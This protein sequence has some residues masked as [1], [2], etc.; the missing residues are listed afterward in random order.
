MSNK[1]WTLEQAENQVGRTAIVTGA[2]VGLGYETALALAG[3]GATVIL[4]C[5]NQEKAAAAR[6][7]ILAVYPNALVECATL[8]TSSLDCVR[9]CATDLL[10]RHDRCDLLI[11]NA[12]IMMTPYQTSVDG[13]ENQLATN[14]IGHFLLTALLLPLITSTAGARVVNLSSLAH[15]WSGIQFHDINFE[16][17]YSRKLAYGQS[18]TACLMFA[19]E[20]Q[21]RLE[22]AGKDTLSMAAHPGFSSTQLG[23]N[24]PFPL[25]KVLPMLS[26]FI[27]QSAADGALPTLYAALGDDLEGG[28]YI[29]PAGK[30]QRKGPPTVVNCR[31]WAKDMASGQRLWA[32]SEQMTG[33]SVAV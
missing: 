25:S 18:K 33:I 28:E 29:G 27:S 13:F 20:L 15:N 1:F 12:G 21:R 30:G 31:S 17:G 22:A 10:A 8:D 26:S 2:N 16:N 4:A 23:R 14:Y 11:N 24:L 19:L 5:R 6:A 7:Q 9:A 32:L 3:I